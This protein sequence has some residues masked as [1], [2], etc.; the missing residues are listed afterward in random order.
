ML[1]LNY[2]G[3]NKDD[4]DGAVA[5]RCRRLKVFPSATGHDN[6]LFRK[7]MKVGHSRLGNLALQEFQEHD[8]LFFFFATSKQAATDS[9]ALNL[10]ASIFA[11][12]S[13]FSVSNM[14]KNT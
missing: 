8:L 11:L 1:T 2:G 13:T 12:I 10:E 3:Q 5:C 6:G 9:D 4:E 7:G 14:C